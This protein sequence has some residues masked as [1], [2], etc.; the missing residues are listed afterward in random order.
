[1]SASGLQSE[2]VAAQAP[3]T[4]CLPAFVRARG[5]IAVEAVQRDARTVR[6]DV[7]ESG[8]LRVRFPREHLKRLDATLVNVAGGMTGGDIFALEF[9]VREGAE[10][11]ISSAAAE[12]IYRS[13]SVAA[14]VSV[15]VNVEA[16]ASCIWLPQ[17]TII[18]NGAELVRKLDAD[19]DAR[20]RF[21]AC[22]MTIL[23][24]AAMAETMDVLSWRERWRIRR[25]GRLVLAEDTRVEGDAVSHLARRA[26][27]HGAH[28]FATLLYMG[29]GAAE[30]CEG[31]RNS[32]GDD[33]AFEAG[34]STFEG[35]T[36]ARF[37]AKDGA[38][39]RAAVMRCV[40]TVENMSLPRG[41]H[42]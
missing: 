21:L 3:V 17:E 42:T 15:R 22:E 35:L 27:G 9:C 7:H 11:F 32:L 31:M 8:A 39:L 28:C 20:A 5:R 37:A 30:I 2:A 36:V 6:A 4:G 13:D 19:V 41:W 29:E 24:R 33:G 12:K 26:T 34:V 10:L 18:F 23:G 1:M 38:V 25:D 14:E 40:A 16:G